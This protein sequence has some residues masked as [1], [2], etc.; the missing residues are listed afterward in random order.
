MFAGIAIY[1]DLVVVLA[2][3]IAAFFWFLSGIG[4]PAKVSPG[5]LIT[6]AEQNAFRDLIAKYCRWSKW[7]AVSAGVAALCMCFSWGLRIVYGIDA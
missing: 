4:L 3:L 6:A 7:A 1:F 2:S 5:Q